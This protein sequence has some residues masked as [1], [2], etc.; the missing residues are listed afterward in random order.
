MRLLF[1]LLL[2]LPSLLPASPPEGYLAQIPVFWRTLYPQGGETLYCGSPFGPFDRRVNIEHVFP[3]AWATKA[4]GCGKRDRCR[5]T[6]PRFNV[7]ESDMHNLYPALREV[8]EARGSYAYA[9]IAGEQHDFADCDFELDHRLRRVEPRPAVRG[10]IAR[11]MLYMAD[12][13]PELTLFGRQ[14]EL[15]EKWHRDDPPSDEERRRND[16]IGRQQGRRNRFIDRPEQ[17]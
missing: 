14:R 2:L 12:T 4:L 10:D 3:M 16:L 11:A 9:L 13:Y 5:R 6:S 1:L 7:I 8:N 17:L 15:M